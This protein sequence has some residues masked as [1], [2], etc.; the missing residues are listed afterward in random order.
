MFLPYRGDDSILWMWTLP[1]CNPRFLSGPWSSRREI[2]LLLTWS[3]SG[4]NW[5][6]PGLLARRSRTRNPY[7]TE[8]PRTIAHGTD[9]TAQV[10]QDESRKKK[11]IKTR[12]VYFETVRTPARESRTHSRDRVAHIC[13]VRKRELSST[14]SPYQFLYVVAN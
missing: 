1:W 14:F 6:L 10:P 5:V 9:R 4:P 2:R 13:A 11:K 8:E 12:N 3:G 7:S